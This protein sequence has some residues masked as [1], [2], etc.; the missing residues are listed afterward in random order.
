MSFLPILLFSGLRKMSSQRNIHDIL[1]DPNDITNVTSPYWHLMVTAMTEGGIDVKQ[2]ANAGCQ[3]RESLKTRFDMMQS[4]PHCQRGFEHVIQNRQEYECRTEERERVT[5]TL[6]DFYGFLEYLRLTLMG[7]VCM[8]TADSSPFFIQHVL[9]NPV[10]WRKMCALAWRNVPKTILTRCDR[11]QLP[12]RIN[13]Q[14]LLSAPTTHVMEEAKDNKKTTEPMIDLILCEDARQSAQYL[15]HYYCFGS[16]YLHGIVK[17]IVEWAYPEDEWVHTCDIRWM[18]SDDTCDKLLSPYML[19]L[20]PNI[21][22]QRLSSMQTKDKSK[23]GPQTT[24]RSLAEK[25]LPSSTVI[26]VSVPLAILNTSLSE[27][28]QSLCSKLISGNNTYLGKDGCTILDL[29]AYAKMD[30]KE[31]PMLYWTNGQRDSLVDEKKLETAQFP[32]KQHFLQ[33]LKS[34]VEMKLGFWLMIVEPEL[35]IS[36]LKPKTKPFYDSDG[37]DD[38]YGDW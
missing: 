38:D 9:M 26:T 27:E 34:A 14:H 23:I 12:L 15:I 3:T 25:P 16:N 21:H 13:K 36:T 4:H 37:S 7:Y 28:Y 29:E 18:L 33:L 24:R 2:F 20:P 31:L 11:H 32:N 22:Y 6:C 30:E 17:L 5:V 35:F 10:M 19:P 1:Q 8:P